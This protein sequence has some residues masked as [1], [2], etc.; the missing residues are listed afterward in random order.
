MLFSTVPGPSSGRVGPFVGDVF[1]DI[2][3]A[4]GR[5]ANI[6]R[7]GLLR[8]ALEADVTVLDDSKWAIQFDV[9]YNKVAGFTV[10]NKKVRSCISYD[11]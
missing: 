9:V 8:G 11:E 4:E 5:I 3:P 6:L 7:L 1:Q 2:K 10:A